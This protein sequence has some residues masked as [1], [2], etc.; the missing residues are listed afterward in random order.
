MKSPR[1]H[2]SASSTFYAWLRRGQGAPSFHRR[3]AGGRLCEDLPK[4]NGAC[5][6]TLPLVLPLGGLAPEGKDRIGGTGCQQLAMEHQRSRPDH[7]STQGCREGTNGACLFSG[8]QAQIQRRSGCW[9]LAV[10]DVVPHGSGA[11]PGLGWGGPMWGTFGYRDPEAQYW[12][13]IMPFP[14]GHRA[15]GTAS[16]RIPGIKTE[17]VPQFRGPRRD[18]SCSDL[19]E[20]GPRNLR[21]LSESLD[22]GCLGIWRSG[23]ESSSYAPTSRRDCPAGLRLGVQ[24]KRCL[25]P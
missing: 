20:T 21:F 25:C 9:L 5:L 8:G 24:A 17:Q 18:V 7:V 3:M 15:E 23:S 10:A 13:V 19:C 4:R 16:H 22:A 12:Q 14:V 1:A 6:Y 11:A 2:P